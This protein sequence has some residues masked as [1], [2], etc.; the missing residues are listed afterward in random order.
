MT[1][2]RQFY[3]IF[4]LLALAVI[5][6]GWGYVGHYRINTDAAL[7]FNQE[8]GQF[9][10]WTSILAEHAS[11]ADERKAWDPTEA[12]K[13]YIDIDNYPEFV[14]NGSIP[15]TLDSVI[16][17]HGYNFVYDQGILPWAT[18]TAFDSL[19]SCFERGDW[20]Q[21][22]L[23]AADLGH[24]VADGHMPLHITRNYNG[25]YTGNQGIH[26]RYESEM[27]GMYINQI[28]Y[29]GYP[30]ET[31]GNVNQY[32]FNYLYQNYTYVDSLI[33]ADDYAEN[34]AG[35]TNSSQYY[36][37][38]WDKTESFTNIMFKRSAHNLAELIYTAWFNAGSPLITS[39]FS[40]FMRK[41]D[42]SLQNS[43]NPFYGKT[44]I[45][46]FIPDD[47][48]VLIEVR[49]LTGSLVAVLVDE[50]KPEGSYQFEFNS[51]GLTDGVYY[52]ILRFKDNAIIRKMIRL[53]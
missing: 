50:V 16:A 43:P 41:N 2:F 23:F 8:M 12:P 21:A 11:D 44:N 52:A 32:I 25:Q 45:T 18:E 30:I 34:L 49:D 15:Q 40:P 1:S 36:A 33:A 4:I 42:I 27:I 13:H 5:L 28:L 47:S 10:Q 39:D 24:Y 53:H 3:S 20:E 31:I 22:V 9:Y 46:Y 7:S 17:L 38:L 29:T 19:Q 37:A 14:L 35:N 48:H 6:S 26:S 51:E